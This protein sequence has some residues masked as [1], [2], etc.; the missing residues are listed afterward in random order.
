MQ[1]EKNEVGQKL[2]FLGVLIDSVKMKISFDP[3]QA[4]GMKQQLESYL[5][6]LL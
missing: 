4:R 2:V 1:M 6:V 5:S 3:V